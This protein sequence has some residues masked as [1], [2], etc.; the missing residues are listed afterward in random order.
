SPQY[1]QCDWPPTEPKI[2]AMASGRIFIPKF[3]F[4]GTICFV[5]LRLTH[6]LVA[7]TSKARWDMASKK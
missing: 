2:P 5:T 6:T 4:T 1:V 3:S 7:L